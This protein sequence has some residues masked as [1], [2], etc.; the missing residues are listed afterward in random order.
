MIKRTVGIWVMAAVLGLSVS[1]YAGGKGGG[2]SHSGGNSGGGNSASH[3]SGHEMGSKSF[4]ESEHKTGE[5]AGERHEKKSQAHSVADNKER[6]A[7]LAGLLPAGTDLQAAAQGF[8]N[9]GQF[10]AAAHVSHNLGI[11]FSDLKTKMLDGASLGSAIKAL[12]PTADSEMEAKKAQR[13][14]SQDVANTK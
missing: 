9:Y 14:A 3:E 2:S 13:Q 8:K 1:A 4:H 7:K 5:G 6:S 11:P 12:K 10:V